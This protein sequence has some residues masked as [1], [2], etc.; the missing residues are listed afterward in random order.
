MTTPQQLAFNNQLFVQQ[1]DAALINAHLPPDTLRAMIQQV[2]ELLSCD[3]ECQQQRQIVNLYDDMINVFYTC[4]FH[5]NV[6][7]INML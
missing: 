3:L 2:N 5:M 4:L 1:L 7:N 6:S